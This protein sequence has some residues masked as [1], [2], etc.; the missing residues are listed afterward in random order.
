M[1]QTNF[2]DIAIDDANAAV[3]G[4]G[5]LTDQLAR[6][7]AD[8]D[9]IKT[10][11]NEVKADFNNHT[12]LCGGDGTYSSIPDGSAAGKT[13]ADARSVSASDVTITTK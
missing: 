4:R 8:L 5:N 7:K 3:E 13:G 10:L 9:N 2:D 12:H 11:L 1:S 6:I